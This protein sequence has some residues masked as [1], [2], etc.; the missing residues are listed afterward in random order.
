VASHGN[1]YWINS[2]ASKG[3]IVVTW[4]NGPPWIV[5]DLKTEGYPS[6]RFVGK[7][8]LTGGNWRDPE[9]KTPLD[10][11]RRELGC[12]LGALVSVLSPVIEPF[13][14][15]FDVCSVE[16]H[17]NP[18]MRKV[19]PET[20]G[21]MYCIASVFSSTLEG[22]ELQEILRIPTAELNRESLRGRIKSTERGVA[23]LTVEDLSS[24]HINNFAAGDGIKLRDYLRERYG[25]K[26]AVRTPHGK[27]IRLTQTTPLTPYA[28]RD[29]LPYLRLNPLKVGTAT[30]QSPFKKV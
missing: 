29:I 21:T 10:L 22:E 17:G 30:Q 26:I 14:D 25:I 9:D 7:Y 20:K 13:A 3:P 5:T 11:Y 2:F 19:L 12:E 18:N 16:Q 8:L 28:E 24:G 23:V 15:Y 4:R 1:N 27:S 6:R